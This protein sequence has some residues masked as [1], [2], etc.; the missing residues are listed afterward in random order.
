MPLAECPR[1]KKKYDID[2][3][4]FIGDLTNLKKSEM[5]TR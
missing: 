5:C 2:L 1:K 4:S 3:L